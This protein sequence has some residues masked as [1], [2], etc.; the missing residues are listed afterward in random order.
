MLQPQ[1]S[2]FKIHFAPS[3]SSDFAAPTPAQGDQVDRIDEYVGADITCE[4]SHSFA[5]TAPFILG[6]EL[7]R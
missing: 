2:R 4:C 3:Q 7:A 6:Q 1:Q 5:Q